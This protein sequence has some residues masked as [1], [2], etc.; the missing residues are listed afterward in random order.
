MRGRIAFINPVTRTGLIFGSDRKRYFFPLETWHDK[1][2]PPRNLEVSFTARAYQ[3]LSVQPF[4]GSE[5]EQ[6][7]FVPVEPA[8]PPPRQAGEHV[9]PDVAVDNFRARQEFS[10]DSVDADEEASYDS[11]GISAFGAAPVEPLVSGEVFPELAEEAAPRL[12]AG[13]LPPPDLTPASSGMPLKYYAIGIAAFILFV[14][15]AYAI[16]HLL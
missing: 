15:I 16:T 5:I 3:A 6:E 11:A 8:G 4:N 7:I 9:V 10:K 2:P 14:L 13:T 12:S 1:V